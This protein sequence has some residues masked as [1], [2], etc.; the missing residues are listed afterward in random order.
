M[1]RGIIGVGILSLV[2]AGLFFDV[3]VA[4][5]LNSANYIIDASISGNFGGNTNS[6]NYKLTSSGGEAIAGSGSGGSYKIGYGYISNLEK[7]LSLTVHPSGLVAAYQL[8]ETTGKAVADESINNAYGS[9]QGTLTS[10][11]GKLGTALS[12]D[13]ATQA[14][15]IA[16]NTQTQLTPTGTIE[17]W[18]KSSTTTGSLAAVSK[19]SSFWLG[20]GNGKATTY[21]WTSGIT[22]SDTTTIA[23]GSWHH[24][25]I[26]LN[27][28]VAAGSTLYVDGVAKKTFIWTPQFQS[29][30]FTLGS[31]YNGTTY[32]QYF[33]GA[34]DHVKVFNRMLSADEILAE[35]NA[36]N[37]GNGSGLSLGSIT[38][39]TSNTAL[40]DIIVHTDSNG[41]TLAINE[42]NDLTSGSFTI[43]AISSGSIA[44][45]VAWNEGSTKGLG[46]TLTAT[47]ATALPG[48]WSSGNSYA[49]IPTTATSFYTRT[50]IQSSTSDYIT[51]RLRADV[52]STQAS[53]PSSYSNI[54]TITGTITP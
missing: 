23:D 13:G 17:T 36:Q 50:G 35:Y 16:N 52:T 49:A 34:V 27:S 11:T 48:T 12:F 37:T 45:P 1:K 51:M 21:D 20:L 46:F 5:R 22:T 26:T 31:V 54:L 2:V 44:S 24:I 18:I 4:D 9:M 32:S 39:G 14:V 15:P 6:G 7:S 30:I 38:S 33:N 3:A 42:N 25:A 8:E 28:G 47:N 40:S 10:V 41:Y 53:T 29:G 19:S 43:P